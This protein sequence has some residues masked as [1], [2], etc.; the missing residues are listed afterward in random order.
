MDDTLKLSLDGPGQCGGLGS[1]AELDTLV[2]VMGR[3][4]VWEKGSTEA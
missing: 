2:K 3:F 4:G 1:G